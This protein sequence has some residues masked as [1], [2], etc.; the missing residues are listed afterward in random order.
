MGGLAST[1][2]SISWASIK[3][4]ACISG[5]SSSKRKKWKSAWFVPPERAIGPSLYCWPGMAFGPGKQDRLLNKGR[6]MDDVEGYQCR[7]DDFSGGHVDENEGRNSLC[8]FRV[9]IRFF[10]FSSI[11]LG[12]GDSVCVCVCVFCCL[13]ISLCWWCFLSSQP[14]T[15][16]AKSVLGFF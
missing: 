12:T 15:L 9:F 2:Q 1:M 11:P 8:V 7:T 3:Y 5:R 4:L 13:I 10:G 16:A 6:C 14:T